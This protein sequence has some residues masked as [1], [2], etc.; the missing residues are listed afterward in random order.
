METVLLLG[1]GPPDITAL[2]SLDERLQVIGL[3]RA[4]P[5]TGGQDEVIDRA[6]ALG[7]PLIPDVGVAGVERA[8][9]DTSPDCVVVSSY[10]RILPS[11]LLAHSRF[12]N[13]HYAPLPEYRG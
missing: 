9:L 3:V 2:D 13:V 1:L 11:R 12:V 5:P 6:H 7:V 4:C 8:V 10:D